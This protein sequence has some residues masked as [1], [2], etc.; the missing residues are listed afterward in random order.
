[1]I[2]KVRNLFT[3]RIAAV[4]YIRQEVQNLITKRIA[5]AQYRCRKADNLLKIVMKI[6]IFHRIAARP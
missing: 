4:Q 1:L 2:E 3:G 5:A 6:L